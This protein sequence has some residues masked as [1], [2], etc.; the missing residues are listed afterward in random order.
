MKQAEDFLSDNLNGDQLTPASKEWRD[1]LFALGDLLHL[2]GRDAEAIAKLEEALKRYPD[3]PQTI[4]ASYLLADSSRRLALSTRAG[5]AKEISSA[6]RSE[7][8]AEV[9][10][11]FHRALE[12]FVALQNDL[13]HR[14]A[15]ELTEQEKSMLRN[16]R[17]TLGDV[18]LDLDR[19]P[20]ALR[21][22]QSAA[23]HYASSPEVLD[24][25]LQIANVYRRMDRPAEARTSLEQ[26]RLALRRIPPE[27]RFEQTTN[28]NRNQWSD[29]LDRLCSL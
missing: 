25:Y 9:S 28:F 10:R 15:E 24:A 29:L 11:N 1:S 21:A 20:E 22:F 27:A 12:I 7:S 3:A 13:S 23:N 2:A 17:F 4:A 16:V 6:V 14:N 18:Y 8:R 26:A 19:Y 5:L